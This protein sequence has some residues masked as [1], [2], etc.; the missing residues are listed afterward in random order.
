MIAEDLH[1]HK[2]FEYDPYTPGALADLGR[3]QATALRFRNFLKRCSERFPHVIY[4]A[5][6]HEF[7]HGR[8]NVIS[9][10]MSISW[11]E[12]LWKLTE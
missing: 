4:V 9:F 6:N 10:L 7:Y 5:G 3:R 12:I 11:K 2:H 1:N 8:W